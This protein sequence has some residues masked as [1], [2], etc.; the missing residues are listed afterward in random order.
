M[1]DEPRDDRNDNDLPR[2]GDLLR[3][4]EDTQRTI[5]FMLQQQAQYQARAEVDMQ[6]LREAQTRTEATVQRFADATFQRFEKVEGEVSNLDRKMEALVDSHIR[7]A[8]THKEAEERLNA[9]IA[10]VERLIQE[11]RN[12]GGSKGG[13]LDE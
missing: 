13:V 4:A 9:F 1:S 10:T 7:M 3:W 2:A 8:D 6:N 11:R 12:G 5:N